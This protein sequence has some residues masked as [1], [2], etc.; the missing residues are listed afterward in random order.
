MLVL[1]DLPRERAAILEILR[2]HGAVMEPES[3]IAAAV[4]RGYADAD[5][6][7]ALWYLID[8][9]DVRLTTGFDVALTENGL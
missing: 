6:R 4:A 1:D 7:A 9:G 8:F 2:E 3:M 5:V